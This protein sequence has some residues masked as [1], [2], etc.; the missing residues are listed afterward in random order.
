[1]NSD[2]SPEQIDAIRAT[3]QLFDKNRDGKISVQELRLAFSN[4]GQNPTDE[5]LNIMVLFLNV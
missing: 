3:F 1:M 4:L 2:P 5:E